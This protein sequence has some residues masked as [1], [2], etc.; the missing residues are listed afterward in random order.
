MPK[1]SLYR[2]EKGNDFHFL[3]RTI[4]EQFQVGGVDIYIHRYLGPVDPLE[5]ESTPGLPN[6]SN[7][8]PEL[9]IQD[10]IF[11]ENRDRHY[12]PDVYVLRGI[13]TMQDLDFNLS[14]FGLF[15][16]NDNLMIHFHLRNTVDALTRKIMPGDV[17]ELP[18]LKDEYA[19]DDNIVALKRFYVVQDVTRPTNGFSQTWYPHLLRAK[20][21]PLVDSQEFKEILDSDA[22][23][24]DG[25]TL[26][27]LMSTYK[28]SIEINNQIIAE[29]DLE[30]PSSGFNTN[31]LYVMP[32][33]A[34]TGL[35]AVADASIASSDASLDQPVLDASAVLKT[36]NK[37]FYVGYLSGDGIPSNGAPYGFGITFPSNPTTGQ[38]YLRTDFL[39]NRLFRYDGK[40]WVRYED[41]VRMTLDNFGSQDVE[42]GAFQGRQVQETLLSGFINNTNKTGST[43]LI[44]GKVTAVSATPGVLTNISYAD[45]M[46]ATV[47]FDNTKHKSTVTRDVS[48]RALITFD[49]PAAAGTHVQW[50]I[51]DKA[52]DERQS[53]SKVLKPRADN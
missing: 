1:L 24:G 43:E 14:Q 2:P 19:L 30:V 5:G 6:N 12:D 50:K 10:L 53:L 34:D 31:N 52:F 49:T 3:D 8:I 17:L 25:S 44:F 21:A 27:D 9:G 32:T 51:F 4:L 33:A 11:M 42:S 23:A 15:L 36:P 18:H 40:H 38:F 26:R 13:Y 37:D 48:G 28:K 22:G 39:P 41:N 7:A 20:C 46:Y 35:I 16:N 45:G 29:A 47:L